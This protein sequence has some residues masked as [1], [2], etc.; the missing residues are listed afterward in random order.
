MCPLS[1]PSILTA[2]NAKGTILMLIICLVGHLGFVLACSLKSFQWALVSR[3]L[4]GLG[5]GSTVVAQGR[6]CAT[7][8]VGREIVFAVA[9]TES[10]HN[11]ANFIAFV[12]VVPVS[13]WMGGYIWSLWLGVGFCVMSLIAGIIFFRVNRDAEPDEEQMEATETDG[14]IE[15]GSDGGGY[16]SLAASPT[17]S[18]GSDVVAE[19]SSCLGLGGLSRVL[20]LGFLLLCVIHMT[21]SNCYHL[22]AYVSATLISDRFHTTVAKAGWLAGL[23]NG[24]AIFLCPL[25]GLFMD[26]AGYKMWILVFCGLLS[27]VSYLLLLSASVTP[28]PSL[29]LLAVVVSFTPTILK[30]AVPNL[31]TPG[32]YGL[33][34]GVYVISESVGSVLGNG[35]VGFI[36]DTTHSWDT[37]IEIFA[38]MAF[39]ATALTVV[40]IA[41]DHYECLGTAAS[42]RPLGGLNQASQ[43]TVRDY[44]R[45]KKRKDRYLARE[46]RKWRRQ[47]EGEARS[48]AAVEA[49]ESGEVVATIGQFK[50]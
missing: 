22:F 23:S 50:Q 6:I 47:E 17:S 46:H 36:R 4:F 18:V 35:V 25:A 9:L 48:D 49:E 33:A 11:L 42:G 30:S 21:Y 45:L 34:Y 37:D 27:T 10:T 38:C 7:W 1:L 41:L 31:V 5:Q 32:V 26:W 14:L 15:N 28:V 2:G 19:P 13:E 20:S 29:I 3:I 24:I 12:Y 44:D 40:L 43:P 16:N 8:F 39:G